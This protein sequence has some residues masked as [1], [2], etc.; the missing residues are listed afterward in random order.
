MPYADVPAFLRQLRERD[1]IAG[2]ALEFLILNASRTGEVIGG[3]RVEVSENG[4]WTIPG[5]RMKAGK[6]HRV[7]L[8]QRSLELLQ[9]ARTLDP[10]SE[11]LFSSKGKPLSNMAMAMLF[12]RM[13][14]NET[15]HGF[16]SSFRDWVSEKT[17]HSPEVA[18]KA[19]AHTIPNKVEAAYRRGDLLEPRRR[20]MEDW[21]QYCLFG[22]MH[23]VVNIE[24]R[25]RA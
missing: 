19:L 4:I 23:N 12:R 13:G 2:L 1:G 7:P 22:C 6:D 3:R 15:V 8:T 18:E 9:V 10:G 16:R 25:R 14:R 20:L 5:T 17:L 11:F 21:A 24:G